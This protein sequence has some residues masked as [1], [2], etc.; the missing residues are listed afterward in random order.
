[1][2]VLSCSNVLVSVYIPWLELRET[3]G[4]MQR[5]CDQGYQ[6]ILAMWRSKVMV[7]IDVLS[8]DEREYHEDGGICC[9]VCKICEIT[10]LGHGLLYY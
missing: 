10:L 1:M 2:Y 7:E 6:K 5:G 8:N 4:G 3:L 9:E